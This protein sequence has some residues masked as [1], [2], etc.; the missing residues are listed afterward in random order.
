MH[1]VFHSLAHVGAAFAV[2]ADE[3]GG[4]HVFAR[5]HLRGVRR[6]NHLV[7]LVREVLERHAHQLHRL[8][9]QKEFRRI[10]EQQCTAQ[11]MVVVVLLYFGEVADERHLD[12]ALRARAHAVDVAFETVVLVYHLERC[13]LE[14]RLERGNGNVELHAHAREQRAQLVVHLAVKTLDFGGLVLAARAQHFAEL[15]QNLVEFAAKTAFQRLENL[16]QQLGERLVALEIPDGDGFREHAL[17]RAVELFG[18]ALPAALLG[19]P[20]V[21]RY[22]CPELDIVGNLAR[23]AL[24]LLYA[25]H[26]VHQVRNHLRG[27][28]FAE[29]VQHVLRDALENAFDFHGNVW[30]VKVRYVERKA[31]KQ[32]ADAHED[33]RLA[34]VVV[35]D[36]RREAAQRERLL[37]DGTQIRNANL[38]KSQGLWL[39]ALNV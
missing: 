16:V 11:V 25:Q 19:T 18:T 17:E 1:G 8:R 33:V 23:H 14:E 6:E 10:D 36:E 4:A 32:P 3:Q 28:L 12:G 15:V 39:H 5:D 30:V 31:R 24:H 22:E 26:A 27:L 9:V 2:L 21:G 34:G 20:V 37:L 35:A 13:R 38:G 29:A 7:A